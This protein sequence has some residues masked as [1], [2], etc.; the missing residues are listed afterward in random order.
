M[1]TP[2]WL[3]VVFIILVTPFLITTSARA[4]NQLIHCN[5]VSSC[6]KNKKDHS[7]ETIRTGQKQ[8]K[9]KKESTGMNNNNNVI[10]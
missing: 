5:M 4:F 7:K 1:T 3:G 6:K 9:Y 8:K 2:C 10:D